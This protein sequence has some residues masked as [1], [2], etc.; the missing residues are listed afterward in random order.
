MN[1]K[2]NKVSKVVKKA[3]GKR[4]LMVVVSFSAVILLTLLTFTAR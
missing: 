4:E 1:V 3:F 2:T